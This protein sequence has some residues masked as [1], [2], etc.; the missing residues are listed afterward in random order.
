[1]LSTPGQLPKAGRT[2]SQVQCA[3]KDG[4]R[5]KAADSKATPAAGIPAGKAQI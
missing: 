2:H 5:G 1:M 3:G 4:L